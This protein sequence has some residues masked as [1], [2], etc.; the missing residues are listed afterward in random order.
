MPLAEGPGIGAQAFRAR[1][2]HRQAGKY[3]G[4]FEAARGQ[5]SSRDT[6]L[7]RT[8][9]SGVALPRS[10]ARGN[11]P[12]GPHLPSQRPGSAHDTTLD[13]TD[14]APQSI[15]HLSVKRWVQAA[16]SLR[17][18]TAFRRVVEMPDQKRGRLAPNW[19]CSS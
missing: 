2:K 3:R 9:G 15:V 5:G 17:A 13:R 7:D 10:H 6:M 8:G 19:G 16:P 12:A 4:A 18:A 14:L 11:A 1:P